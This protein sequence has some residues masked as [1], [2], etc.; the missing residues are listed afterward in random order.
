MSIVQEFKDF[1]VKGNAVDLAVGVV[2]GAAFGAIT[3]SLVDDF[4]NPP[5]GFILGGIDFDNMGVTLREATETTEAVVINYGAFISSLI[6]FLVIAFV[7]FLVVKTMNHLRRQM[8][9]DKEDEDK[10]KPAPPT[11]IKLLTEIRDLLKMNS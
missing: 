6:N 10:T 7:L 1:A 2:V 3:N 11:D 5:L 9:Q 4:I 8:E